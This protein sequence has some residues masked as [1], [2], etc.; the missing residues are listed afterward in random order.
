MVPTSAMRSCQLPRP[1]KQW[2]RRA[3]AMLAPEDVWRFA[4]ETHQNREK[5][6]GRE[7]PKGRAQCAVVGRTWW[8]ASVKVQEK[9]NCRIVDVKVAYRV[10]IPQEKCKSQYIREPPHKTGSGGFFPHLKGPRSFWFFHSR[11][12]KRINLSS[13]WTTDGST[14]ALHD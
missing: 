13:S 8:C 14:C 11:T 1:G 9:G 2:A 10:P 3:C 12:T 7:P 6:V 5:F 4:L